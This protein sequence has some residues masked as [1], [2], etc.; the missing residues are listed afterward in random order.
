MLIVVKYWLHI[1]LYLNKICTVPETGKC[2]I[3][4]NIHGSEKMRHLPVLHSF[5]IHVGLPCIQ[6]QPPSIPNKN[7]K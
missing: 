1:I 2:E 5:K 3:Q 6:A 4:C 7:K